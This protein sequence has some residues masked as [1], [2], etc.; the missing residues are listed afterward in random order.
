MCIYIS[1][2]LSL[3][4]SLLTD[5]DMHI[6]VYTYIYIY[7]MYAMV[8]GALEVWAPRQEILHEG[9]SARSSKGNWGLPLPRALDLS[10]SDPS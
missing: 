7:N 4:L 5:I 6:H 10:G 2:S 8:L 1:L 9:R 3:S